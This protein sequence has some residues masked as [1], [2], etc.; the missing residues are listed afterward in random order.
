[1][2]NSFQGR[3]GREREVATFMFRGSIQH[4][5]VKGRS[6]VEPRSASSALS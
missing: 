1:M 5:G 2:K 3:V 4:Q 6:R